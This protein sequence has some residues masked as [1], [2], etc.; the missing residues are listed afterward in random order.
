MLQPHNGYTDM[1]KW[2]EN[3]LTSA[4]DDHTGLL[5]L[6]VEYIIECFI[7]EEGACHIDILKK[8]LRYQ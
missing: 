7:G 1:R 6:L 4:K 5:L 8:Q 2:Y 3:E